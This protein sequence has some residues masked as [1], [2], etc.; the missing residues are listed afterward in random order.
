MTAMNIHAELMGPPKVS[1]SLSANLIGP[2]CDRHNGADDELA[3]TAVHACLPSCALP[4]SKL[5][6]KCTDCWAVSDCQHVCLSAPEPAESAVLHAGYL[7]MLN[8]D[9]ATNTYGL[10]AISVVVAFLCGLAS[11]TPFKYTAFLALI[12]Y[13]SLVFNQV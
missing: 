6:V 12:T 8:S 10:M 3:A 2:T 1:I 11:T 5:Q 9:L 4:Q 13:A 7:C